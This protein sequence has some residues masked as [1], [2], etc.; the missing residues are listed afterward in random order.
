MAE[1]DLDQLLDEVEHK[2]CAPRVPSVS[3]RGKGAGGA[4]RRRR[5][6]APVK[7]STG[8]D[9]LDDLIEDIL[10]ISCHDKNTTQKPRPQNQPA[11]R[12]SY[13]MHSKKCGPVYVAGSSVPFGIGTSISER[14]CDQLRCTACD[15]NVM[16]FDNSQWDA[17]CDYLFFRNSMPD[18]SKLRPKLIR[19]K[20]SRAYACQCSWRSVQELTNIT[21]YPQLRWVCGK[22]SQ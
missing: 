4:E 5:E 21:V 20:G 17:S 2:Y 9:S 15:F 3:S 22:H 7:A 12:S 19:K 8:G 6:N 18:L 16:V 11:C 1:D 10:D 14:A 13:Q